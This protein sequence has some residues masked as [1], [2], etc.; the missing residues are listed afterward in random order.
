MTLG[1][2]DLVLVGLIGI[3]VLIGFF[4]GFVKELIS[5]IT[6]VI[7]IYMAIM[8]ASP[9]AAYMKFTSVAVVRSLIAFLLIF[10]GTVFV[11]AVIN[12]I[13]GSIVRATPFSLA[14]RI[15]GSGFGFLRGLAFGTI[16]VL[17][18][19][20]TPLPQS[21]WWQDSLLVTQFQVLAVWFKDQLPAEHGRNF[22]F[23]KIKREAIGT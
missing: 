14:D 20:L 10:V 22:Q 23:D 4:R 18:G 9:L 21:K 17:L 13:V 19:G 5:L 15:L 6:W 3:S 16:L 7:A 2:P 1:T 11:G 8:Y 12:Y